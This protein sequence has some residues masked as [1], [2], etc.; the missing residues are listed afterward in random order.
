MDEIQSL[1]VSAMDPGE[2]T[3]LVLLLLKPDHFRVLET[4][5]IPYLPDRRV[6]PLDTLW[7]WTRQ[8][9]D[10]KHVLVYENFRRRTGTPQAN[11]TALRVLGGMEDRIMQGNPYARVISQEPVHKSAAP[12]QLLDS[13]GLRASGPDAR[14]VRDAF[15]H[16]VVWAQGW[17]YIPMFP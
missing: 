17:G 11:T 12:D 4:C 2:T 6:T 14:H 9:R 10:L 15:R 3:G 1:Y 13:L 8:L 7:G 5:A 16:A